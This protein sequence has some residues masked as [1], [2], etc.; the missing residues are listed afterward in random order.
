MGCIVEALDPANFRKNQ[1]KGEDLE[2]H[3]YLCITYEVTIFQ[4]ICRKYVDLS[5]K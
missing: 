4:V 5:T 2:G 3:L 1:T